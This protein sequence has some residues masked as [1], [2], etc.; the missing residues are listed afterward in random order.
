MVE[1]WTNSQ[2][3]NDKLIG[4]GNNIIYKANPKTDEETEELARGL[5][6]GSFDKSK[7]W[8]INTKNC[9]EIR[10]QEGKACIEIFWGKDGEE[11]LRITDE[12]MRYQI[13]EK[14]KSNTTHATFKIEK[15]NA[16]RA[17]RKPM[18]AF[19][20]LAGLF[21]WTLYYAI[22]AQSGVVYY[23]E[24]GRYASITGIVLGLASMGLKN[25]ITLFSVLLGI[26]LFAF[27]S[28]A[29]NPPVMNRIIITK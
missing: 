17:G 15:W 2:K 9:K 7:I 23:I 8:D 22:Q 13:F 18:I 29:K 6:S 20:V 25:V 4:F 12:Y 16:I 10:L 14:I 27:W 3:N 11:Q 1:V 26:S 24:S 28:K 5:R 19:F 21:C